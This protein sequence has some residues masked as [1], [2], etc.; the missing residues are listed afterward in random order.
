LIV[1]D[2]FKFR[3]GLVDG[4]EYG[5]GTFYLEMQNGSQIIEEVFG[6]SCRLQNGWFVCKE[7]QC[8][9]IFVNQLEV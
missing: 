7:F 3:E 1:G 4:E 6:K 8:T 5:M 2:T 9:K